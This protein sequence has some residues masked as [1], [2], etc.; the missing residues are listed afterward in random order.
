MLKSMTG[1]GRCEHTIG[2][3]TFLVEIRSLN[4]KQFEALLK[5]PQLLKPY[6]FEIR[7]LLSERLLRG[8][9]E[10]TVTMRVNGAAK[11]VTI[12][13]DLAKSYYT[14][15]KSLTDA[16]GLDTSNIL[17][18]LLKLPEV[19]VPN[20]DSFSESDWTTFKD[21]LLRAIG[22]LDAHRINEGRALELDLIERILNIEKL[23]L[24]VMRV[25]PQR[26]EKIRDHIRKT[27]EEQV[28]PDR[29]DSNR[30]EQELIYHIEKIDISE[31]QVRLSNHCTYFRSILEE[32]GDGKGKKLSFVLQEVGREINTTG[33]K[34]YDAEIQ[35]SVVLM[36]DELEKAKEQVLNVL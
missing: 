22:E 27:L 28:G 30:L 16:L 17:D 18:A 33:S 1:Y 7:G 19:I 4:G 2:D 34:A 13:T 36:K 29:Y 15:L 20:T 8:S 9:I 10:C 31:E 25:E 11:P 14:Q 3:R 21:V 32:P 5:I 12:N 26:R 24:E 23:Q 35:R 6:E